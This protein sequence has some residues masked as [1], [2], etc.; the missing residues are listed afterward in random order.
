MW[1]VR[2]RGWKGR[3]ESEGG[4]TAWITVRERGAA[5]LT[6]LAHAGAAALRECLPTPRLHTRNTILQFQLRLIAKQP[7]DRTMTT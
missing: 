6:E 3:A 7:E 2:R 1:G 5:S 4:M